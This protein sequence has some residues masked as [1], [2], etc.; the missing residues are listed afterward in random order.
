MTSRWPGSLDDNL[1]H[2]NDEGKGVEVAEGPALP[3]V[4]ND[5]STSIAACFL[6]DYEASRPPTFSTNIDGIDT[7]K[8]Q[9]FRLQF[10]VWWR[11][12]GL[13]PATILLFVSNFESRGWTAV[14]HILAI[15]IFVVDIHLRYQIS[16][17]SSNYS[18]NRIEHGIQRSFLVF[19]TLMAIQTSFWP[20]VN[21]PETHFSTLMISVF[22]PLVFFYLSRRA[23]DAL[24]ALTK[25]GSILLRVIV[26][27]MFLIL[28]FAG[29][30]CRL[31]YDDE[32]FQNLAVS[33]L[34]LFQRKQ[35][36][37]WNKSFM[38]GTNE[39]FYVFINSL[40]HGCEP[41]PLASGVRRKFAQRNFLCYIHCC[42]CLLSTF[43]D[44][45]SCVSSFYPSSNRSPQPFHEREG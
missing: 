7:Q 44:T 42:L 6:M 28:T 2:P 4:N 27:E 20:F 37:M 25:I 26:I 12:L 18:S 9:Y 43:F 41:K 40:Y 31:Y 30:A 36:S 10:S 23:R 3:P 32:N 16:S 13:Y 29:V 8:L 11:W 35:N 38:V 1:L 39:S 34:S 14:A 24:E 22:K 5:N 21:N 19:L 17:S 15:A 33:W 45:F